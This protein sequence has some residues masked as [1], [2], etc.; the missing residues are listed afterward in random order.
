MDFKSHAVNKAWGF[1]A[2]LYANEK[3][4]V[5]ILNIKKGHATSLHLHPKKKTA[6]I[7]LSGRVEI[8]FLNSSVV[9]EAPYKCNIH[10]RVPHRTRALSDDVLLLESECPNDKFDLVRIKDD[11]N[12]EV[13][14]YEGKKHYFP[15]PLG[16]LDPDDKWSMGQLGL[17]LT[18]L[19]RGTLEYVSPGSIYVITDGE[20]WYDKTTP[21]ITLGDC[22]RGEDLTSLVKDLDL[23]FA[24]N[25][26]WLGV[27]RFSPPTVSSEEV[28]RLCTI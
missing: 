20:C 23:T 2:E 27:L 25:H 14:N 5:W 24:P 4:S 26:N 15:R 1:E 19:R 28:E 17:S 21:I 7:V 22:I 9:V 3:V 11:Y 12:R 10:P 18:S 8:S 13:Y 6:L 16:R